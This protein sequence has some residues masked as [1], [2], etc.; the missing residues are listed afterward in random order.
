MNFAL[1]SVNEDYQN[2]NSHAENNNI[3]A[4]EHQKNAVFTLIY[5]FCMPCLV[6]KKAI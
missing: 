5:H 4:K 1:Q 3:I 6:L 2:F